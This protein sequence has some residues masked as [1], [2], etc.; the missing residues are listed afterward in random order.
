M[1]L[2]LG[3]VLVLFSAYTGWIVWQF[4]YTSV[5]EVTLQQHPSTQVLLDLYIA[6]SILFWLMI[7]D[8]KR[9]GRSFK[10]VLPYLTVTLFFGAI[11][12]LIYFLVYPDLLKLK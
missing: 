9:Q 6:G 10:K 7:V 12:P 3:L 5:F 1:R 4:G 11:G 2:L 8:N